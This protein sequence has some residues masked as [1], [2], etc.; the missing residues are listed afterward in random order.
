MDALVVDMQRAAQWLK[1]NAA[2]S[3]FLSLPFVLKDAL[4]SWQ[5]N[6][7]GFNDLRQCLVGRDI[8]ELR[9]DGR[10]LVHNPEAL[11]FLPPVLNP[12][13]FRD[14]YAFEQHVKASR[15]QRGL[16][17]HPDWYRFP[18]FYLSNPNALYGH[19][20]NI[21]YPHGTNELDF[22]LELAIVIANGGQD[23]SRQEAD[24]FI[25]GYT[26]CNDW[27]ARDWQR[28][29]MQLNLGPTKGKDF[30]TSFGPYL[31]T[32][33]ELSAKRGAD[34]KVHLV[35]QAWVNRKKTSE[36]N[37]TDM[38]HSFA[39]M[40]ERASRN[41]ML[42]PGDYIASGTCGT[43]CIME[44]RPENT[45]GWLKRGDIVRFEVEGLGVLENTIV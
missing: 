40:I 7:A 41:A 36:A 11:E 19:G 34:G 8:S 6:L 10:A 3:E 23:I 25:A 2:R 27:S 39:A 16:D 15:K 24:Q 13:T 12:S 31:V 32:P 30:A 37:S 38:Y 26:I 43:G 9:V 29:E 22:E 28:E 18:V 17:I 45:G 1:N 42:M 33:D 14:F 5:A 44:L 21:K 4:T 20:A 35:M